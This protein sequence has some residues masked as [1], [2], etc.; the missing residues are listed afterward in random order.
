MSVCRRYDRSGVAVNIYGEPVDPDACW[1]CG[2]SESEH[3]FILQPN[4][5]S[6]HGPM[7]TNRRHEVSVGGFEVRIF[8]SAASGLSEGEHLNRYERLQIPKLVREMLAKTFAANNCPLEVEIEFEDD[9]CGGTECCR[10]CGGY[11]PSQPCGVR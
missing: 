5:D 1:N 3:G 6:I 8:P 10:D 9:E 7:S 2:R 11:H 4:I